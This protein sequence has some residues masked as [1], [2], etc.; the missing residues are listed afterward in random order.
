M[1]NFDFNEGDIRIAL[2]EK[3]FSEKYNIRYHEALFVRYLSEAQDITIEQLDIL[4][5]KNRKGSQ[6]IDNLLIH[7][8]MFNSQSYILFSDYLKNAKFDDKAMFEVAIASQ[9]YYH[10][11]ENIQYDSSMYYA[12]Y[13][14]ILRHD[15]IKLTM[16]TLDNARSKFENDYR[17]IIKNYHLAN[18]VNG[19]IKYLMINCHSNVSK[20]EAGIILEEY[21]NIYE[22]EKVDIVKEYTKKKRIRYYYS[23]GC[24]IAGGDIGNSDVM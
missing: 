21:S 16:N 14:E 17:E 24:D 3:Q 9:M 5:E 1:I 6:L 10:K 22:K 11:K 19:N 13:D 2:K 23:I 4:N 15:G 7:K 12:I 8:D 18:L 20:K